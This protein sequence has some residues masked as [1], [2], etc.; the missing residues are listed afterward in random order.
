[1]IAES[2]KLAEDRKSMIVR[3]YEA[4]GARGKAR[5]SI[6]LQVREVRRTDL[7]ERETGEVEVIQEG[8]V[9]LKLRPFEIV[10]LKLMIA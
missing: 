7:L 4:H 5:L 8:A 2:V 1:M 3:I 10:T 6:G 9:S